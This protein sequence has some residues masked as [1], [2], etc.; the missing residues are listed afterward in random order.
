[1]FSLKYIL[2]LLGIYTVSS[3]YSEFKI[4][5]IVL[6]RELKN[7]KSFFLFKRYFFF[8]KN[9]LLLLFKLSNNYV[10]NIQVDDFNFKLT[11]LKYKLGEGI[12]QRIEGI[13]EPS[14]VTA[15]K[16]L[17]KEGNKVLELG[18]CYGYF[19]SI[20]SL[21]AKNR[22]KVV[23]IEGLPNNYKILKK[24][25]E[26]NKFK[27]VFSYNYFL[28]NNSKS[29]FIYFDKFA[30]NPYKGIEKYSSNEENSPDVK[31]NDYVRVIRLSDFLKKIKFY[32]DNIFMDIEG[33]EVDVLE[34][35][36]K[37]YLRKK[38]KPTIVFEIH[39]T[40][41]KNNKNLN[42]IKSILKSKYDYREDSGNLICIPIS[43]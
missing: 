23:A 32:P 43:N 29:K 11:F 41:Y 14:T 16:S 9:L 2:S 20:M 5:F 18:S 33:F 40:I 34:D 36:L 27:N 24:N 15:I 25:I 38:K 12:A 22:G 3:A 39:D 26:L 19:T 37:N 4:P 21:C 13:R 42:Y 30:D 10:H 28:S 31:K 35:L 7:L 1:M 17:V 8:K 6:K